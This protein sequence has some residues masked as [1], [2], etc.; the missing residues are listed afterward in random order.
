ML[1]FAYIANGKLPKIKA[2][3]KIEFDKLFVRGIREPIKIRFLEGP[4]FRMFHWTS[5]NYGVNIKKYCESDCELCK[6]YKNASNIRL[7]PQIEYISL[8]ADLNRNMKI[9]YFP[10][11]LA[12]QL[13]RMGKIEDDRV[14]EIEKFKDMLNTGIP[15]VSYKISKTKQFIRRF[16]GS[17]KLFDSIVKQEGYK[18]V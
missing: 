15:I 5:D 12:E 4:A 8:V 14:V 3:P 18:Y 6:E 1:K 17:D 10:K 16:K 11:Q 7:K 2:R 9:I 13:L